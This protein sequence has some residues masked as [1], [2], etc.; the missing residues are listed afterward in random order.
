M[1][2][3]GCSCELS[4]RELQGRIKSHNLRANPDFLPRSAR[5]SHVCAFLLGKAHVVRQRRQDLQEIRGT[6][7]RDLRCAIRVP[8]TYRSTFTL[9]FAV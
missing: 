6:Q 4:G 3:G 5:Q 7:G 1:I 9:S 8:H 2:V